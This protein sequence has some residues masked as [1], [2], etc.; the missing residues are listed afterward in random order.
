[1]ADQV[2]A[3]EN[4]LVHDPNM[5]I[6]RQIIAGQAVPPDLLDAYRV[7]VGDAAAAQAPGEDA[8]S[9]TGD[10]DGLSVE[11]LERRARDAGVYGSIEGTGANGNVVKGDLVKALGASGA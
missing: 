8:R 6:D 7:K 1:M 2:I 4:T 5:G 9:D 3:T 11:E 10:L